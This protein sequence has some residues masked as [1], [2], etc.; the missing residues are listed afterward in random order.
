MRSL[1]GQF[2][3]SHILP[4]VVILPIAGLVILYLVEA[5]IVLADLSANLEERAALIAEAIA[6]QPHVLTDPDAAQRFVNEYGPLTEGDIYLVDAGGAILA[7]EHGLNAAPDP[8]IISGAAD[9]PET[10]RVAMNYGL[11]TQGGEALAP[12]IDVNEQLIGLVGVRESLTGLA[13]AFGPLRRLVLFTILGGMVIGALVGYWLAGRLE[14]PISRTSAAVSAMVGGNGSVTIPAE[15]PQELRDLSRS[16]N[17][18]SSRLRSL[19]EMRRRSFA[20][21]VHELGRPLGAVLA[22]VQVL[23]GEAGEDAAIRAELLGGIQEQ[24]MSMEPL[25]DDLSQ[26]HADAT[27]LQR[28]DRRALGLSGW[29]EAILPPWRE[30]AQAKNLAWVAE[31]PG[32]LPEVEIDPQRMAQVVGNLLS[33]AIKYTPAGGV[34]V[35]A[36]AGSTE[37]RIAI[38]DTGPGIPQDEQALIFEPFYRG[39]SAGPMTEGLGVGLSIARS[40]T[41]AHGGRLTLDSAPGRGSVF[42]I[43]LPILSRTIGTQ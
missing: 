32:D 4:F 43:H 12:V 15:G 5:Q 34:S 40:L 10:V 6:Q 38:A 20:N 7:A 39:H 22:G 30:M 27:G 1:R 19:E 8:A 11:A 3:L 14:R 42:T 25:L 17:V 9:S 2:I 18:L 29:L 24:L 23:R 35:S 28:L 26:L 41:E 37:A 36:T 16:V 13:A 31:I 21:I 33:N